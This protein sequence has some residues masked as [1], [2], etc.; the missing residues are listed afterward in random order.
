MASF[1]L[2]HSPLVGPTTWSWLA[3]ELRQQGHHV[4][5]PSLLEAAI[6]GSWQECVSAVVAAAPPGVP[7]VGVG[8]SGAGPLLPAIAAQLNPWP[9][10][11]VFVDATVP[12]ANGPAALVP[13]QFLEPLTALAQDGILPPWSE[14]FEPGTME[15]L[16]PGP[17]RREVVLAELPRLPLSLFRARI[18]MPHGWASAACA[19]IHLSDAYRE[20]A[21][22]AA[23]R[24]WPVIQ[25]LGSHLDFITQPERLVGALL[26]QASEE[27]PPPP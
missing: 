10:R 18:P 1:L 4:A 20:D 14:W 12:P 19:Y 9:A 25:L 5:V 27:R 15:T 3:E 21:A 24:G 2:V 13:E 16:I 23:S 7:V 22:G 6:S 11:L 8:H 17:A 26:Q